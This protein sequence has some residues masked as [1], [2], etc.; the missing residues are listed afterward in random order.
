[1]PEGKREVNYYAHTTVSPDGTPDPNLAN[2]Q[3][4]CTHLLKVADLAKQFAAPL[5]WG[6]GVVVQGVVVSYPRV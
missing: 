1:M 3:L 6:Y 4:L 2:W 5:G